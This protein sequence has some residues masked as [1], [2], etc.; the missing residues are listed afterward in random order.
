M[1][2]PGSSV[3]TS[4]TA[5]EAL[6]KHVLFLEIRGNNFRPTFIPLRNVRPLM[7]KEIVLSELEAAPQTDEMIEECLRTV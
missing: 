5:G 2:Q 1:I 7:F 6:R 4:L 3:A